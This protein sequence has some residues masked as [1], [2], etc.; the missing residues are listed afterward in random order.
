[1]SR[2][3]LIF[4]AS[5]M[6]LAGCGGGAVQDPGAAS[7]ETVTATVTV[8]TTPSPTEPEDPTPSP[9]DEPSET[10]AEPAIE[11]PSED[12]ELARDDFF[13]ATSEWE[14]GRWNVANRS[15]EKGI[16]LLIR[17]GRTAELE[18]RLQNRYESLRF[19]AGQS[20]DSPS[21]ECVSKV[22]IIVDGELRETREFGF[23]VIQEFGDVDVRDSN[24]V[25]LEV[26]NS[27]CSGGYAL[28]V[29]S[30]IRVE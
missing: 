3:A 8:T 20:N 14:D 15:S 29:L 22:D 17:S 5:T 6:A 16:G 27:Q 11:L 30:R 2:R 10:T 24:A 12:R 13:N 9:T 25:K 7:P 18:L 23:N 4:V 19:D 26:S 1:M 28:V 21:S